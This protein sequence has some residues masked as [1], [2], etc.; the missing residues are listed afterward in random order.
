LRARVLSNQWL[1]DQTHVAAEIAGR[2]IVAV[3][4]QRVA[5]RVGEEIPFDVAAS[6]LHLF[7]SASGRVIAHGGAPA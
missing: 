1:G 2:L 5:V 3:A 7:D 4:H 6:D